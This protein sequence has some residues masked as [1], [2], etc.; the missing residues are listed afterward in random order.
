[1]KERRRFVR[2]NG[3][4]LIEYKG[5]QV[6]GKSSALDV[7]ADGVRLTLDKELKIGFQV[8]MEMYLPGDSQPIKAQGEVIWVQKCKEIPGAQAEGKEGYF[9]TGIK[10]TVIDEDNKKKITNYVYRKFRQAE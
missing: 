4:V 5:L 3:L 10:F 1:M 9:Y 8:D 6:E 2:S 7:S